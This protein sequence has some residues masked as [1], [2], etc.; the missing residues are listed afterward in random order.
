MDKCKHVGKFTGIGQSVVPMTGKLFIIISSVC[1][2]CGT[3]KIET[4][5]VEVSAPTVTP[6]I[7]TN[8]GK[9]S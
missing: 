8:N 9:R 7:T 5:F 4:K 1:G 6:A 2:E 3:P